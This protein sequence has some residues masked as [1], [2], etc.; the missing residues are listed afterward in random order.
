MT[1]YTRP[2]TQRETVLDKPITRIDLHQVRRGV[3]VRKYAAGW[4]P[5]TPPVPP[6]NTNTEMTLEQMIS[7]LRSHGWTVRTWL[8]GARAWLGK[9]RPVRERMDLKYSRKRLIELKALGHGPLQDV[10]IATLDLLYDW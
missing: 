4:D 1:V 10:D 8:G 2:Q 5:S 7:W 6:S 9:P 3:L